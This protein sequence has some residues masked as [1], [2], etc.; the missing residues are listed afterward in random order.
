MLN[1]T[2]ETMVERSKCGQALQTLGIV[3]LGSCFEQFLDA[4]CE[5]QKGFVLP[6]KVIQAMKEFHPT[7]FP[8]SLVVHGMR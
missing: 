2:S 3:V 5:T 4:G 6:A 8:R 7:S 1:N